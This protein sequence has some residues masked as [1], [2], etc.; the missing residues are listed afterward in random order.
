MLYDGDDVSN[1]EDDNVDVN[2]YRD[3]SDAKLLNLEQQNANEKKEKVSK[4]KQE[5]SHDKLV[6]SIRA[7]IVH[8]APKSKKY[9][10]RFLYTTWR[11]PL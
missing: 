4:S 5:M 6:I 3:G 2:P 9:G 10:K 8:V 1:D 7:S 11:T